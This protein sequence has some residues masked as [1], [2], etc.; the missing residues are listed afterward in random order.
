MDILTIYAIA[1]GGIFTSLVIFRALKVFAPWSNTINVFISR[2]LAYPYVLGRHSLLGPWTRAGVSLHLIYLAIN[3]LLLFFNHISMAAAG[4]RAGT[5]SLLNMIFLLASWHLSNLADIFGISLRIYRRMHRAA[6]WMVVA[7]A[8]F[9][10]FAMLQGKSHE[11]QGM[12]TGRLSA[13]IGAGCLCSLVILSLPFCRKVSYELFLRLH[14]ALV[15]ASVYGIWRH[16]PGETYSSRFYLYV[17][18]GILGFT[19]L[20]HLIL[21]LYR[22]GLFSG[23]GCPRAIA[24]CHTNERDAENA[25]QHV[26]TTPIR[27][28]L[29]LPRPVKAMAGQYINLW[30]PSLSLWSWAQTHPF[31]ITSWS[32]ADQGVLDLLVEPRGGLTKALVRQAHAAAKDNFSSLALY[33]GP[34]G[35]SESVDKYESVL[36]VASEAG[37]AAIIP[38]AKKLIHGYNTCTSHV[39]RVHLIWQVESLGWFFCS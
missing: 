15:V 4:R 31:M 17:A 27:V 18:L 9:H 20:S 13:I 37:I 12:N 36:L 38:Y 11:D 35:I 10:V 28:R 30:L 19:S 21:L 7:L 24:I 29:I 14:Q 1:V 6:G 3:L 16:L 5:L 8:L 32:R 33:S 2:H 23:N 26:R 22:N 25:G 39:R 34:H